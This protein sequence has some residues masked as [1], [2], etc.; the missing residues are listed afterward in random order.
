MLRVTGNGM[1]LCISSV[2]AT[3]TQDLSNQKSA[4]VYCLGRATE[5]AE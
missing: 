4:L 2:A 5:T 3:T 1:T